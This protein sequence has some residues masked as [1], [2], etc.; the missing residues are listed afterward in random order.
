MHLAMKLVIS[1][2]I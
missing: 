2:N 1:A